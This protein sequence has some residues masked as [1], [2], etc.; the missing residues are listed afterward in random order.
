MQIPDD[1]TIYFRQVNDPYRDSGIFWH[2]E[3]YLNS[4][5][6][7]VALAVVVA[8]GG[9]AQ[10]NMIFVVDHWRGRGLAHQ[11]IQSCVNRWPE[12]QPTFPMDEGGMSLMKYFPSL[13][14][15]Q[16]DE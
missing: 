4:P 7:P 15:C 13:V 10:L 12:I 11:L 6:F 9:S 5:L 14:D 8:V 2:V 1:I 16:S 3:L